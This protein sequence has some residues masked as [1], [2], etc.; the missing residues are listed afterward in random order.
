MKYFIQLVIQ[1]K[2]DTDWRAFLYFRPTFSSTTEL[3]LR[4]YG[5]NPI[6]AAQNAWNKYNEFEEED[7][8]TK[9]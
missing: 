7:E 2:A 9:N 5:D 8:T 6:A 1:E 3:E 4:A